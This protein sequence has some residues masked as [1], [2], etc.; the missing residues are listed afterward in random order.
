MTSYM[1]VL[2][3]LFYKFLGAGLVLITAIMTARFLGPEGRGFLTTITNNLAIYS[4]F[5]GAYSEYIPYG[6]NKR[7]QSPAKVFSTTLFFCFLLVSVIFLV[8]LL[9]TPW[10]WETFWQGK[11]T[12]AMAWW[13]A[14]LAAPFALL[15][16]YVTRLVLGLNE[17]QWLNRLNTLQSMLII[18][19]IIAA[20][21]L[22]TEY[23]DKVCFTFIAWLASY[24]LTSLI[25][26]VVAVKKGKVSLWP[27]ADRSLL[28]E[29]FRYGNQLA[30]SRLL[31]QINYRIDF[32]L[33]L[34]LI[35]VETAG[36]YSVAIT[37]AD[38]LLFVSSSLLQVVLTRVSSLEEKDSSLL[39]AR[40]FRHTGVI[41]LASLIIFYLL[42][43]TVIR[44]AF[45]EKFEPSLVPFYIL[46]PGVAMLGLA[47]VLTSFFT[48]Q[49]G[50]PKI[51]IRLEAVSV[52]S[53]VVLTLFFY[54]LLHFGAAG[55]ALAK[56]TGYL[57][58]FSIA[59]F[60]FCKAT[61]YSPRKLFVLQP[62]E[63]GQYKNLLGKL[64]S[65]LRKKDQR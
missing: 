15:H 36:I 45:G 21:T 59:V 5:V 1:R 64:T 57:I 61:E 58:I 28:K 4:P 8:A 7:K 38:M 60:Y 31:T 55:M 40:T 25:S 37:V 62:D 53:N 11:P 2:W 33:V 43:P 52:V 27:K 12:E 26:A 63:I 42:M 13:I 48:N 22:P 65:K 18:P 44:L 47:N 16:V 20:C 35:G 19:L 30:G 50:Q 17:L 24:V 34:F 51:L 41:L 54:G 23:G 56:S 39:T 9:V 46:L 3:A 6:I 10:F 14:G 32:Y 29:V 49:L